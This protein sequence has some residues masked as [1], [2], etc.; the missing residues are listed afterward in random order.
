MPDLIRTAVTA[1]F[2]EQRQR[3]APLAAL[4]ILAATPAQSHEPLVRTIAHAGTMHVEAIRSFDILE[5]AGLTLIIGA[6]I[7]AAVTA[8]LLVR[9]H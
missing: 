5:L 3:P 2:S 7:S 4:A 9:T 8:V 6:L 1:C